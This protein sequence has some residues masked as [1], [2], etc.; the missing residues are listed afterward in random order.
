MK[1]IILGL[2]FTAIL[3]TAP[4]A[5]RMADQLRQG[6]SRPESLTISE[7]MWFDLHDRLEKEDGI[8][9]LTGVRASTQRP[10]DVV[11]IIT[12]NRPVPVDLIEEL[13][14]MIDDGM[15]TDVKVKMS[16]IQQGVT[17]EPQA[18][19]ATQEDPDE[20]VINE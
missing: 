11:L 4:L 19:A 6:Q 7:E 17:D 10:E 9:F 18:V 5:F 12:A 8:D 14:Q 16:I 2:G 20:P 15:G 13:D 1:R 3:L